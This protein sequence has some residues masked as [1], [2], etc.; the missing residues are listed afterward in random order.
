MSQLFRKI[1]RKEIKRFF[2]VVIERQDP[3]QISAWD[4]GSLDPNQAWSE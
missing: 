1:L 3:T 2:W 4:R